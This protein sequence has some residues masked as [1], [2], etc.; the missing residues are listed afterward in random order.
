MNRVVEY[1][2]NFKEI[3]SYDAVKTM[4]GHSSEEWQH[5]NHKGK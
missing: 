1:D 4:G 2:K 3:W 5:A